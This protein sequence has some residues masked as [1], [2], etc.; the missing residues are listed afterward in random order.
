MKKNVVLVEDDSFIIQMYLAKLEEIEVEVSA[1]SNPLEAQK[2]L[3][4]SDI[5]F[6]LFLFDLLLPD[7]TGYE[8]LEWCKNT[9]KIKD[10]PVVIMSNLSSQKDINEAYEKGAVDFIV[11]SNYTPSE[12]LKVIKKHLKI[13]N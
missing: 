8:L 11:K 5:Y 1:F 7:I 6:E 4:A 13:I 9:P 3:E 10:V 12:V 2:F